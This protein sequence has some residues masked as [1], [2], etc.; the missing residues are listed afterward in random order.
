MERKREMDKKKRIRN[1]NK[2]EEISIIR[3]KKMTNGEL[4]KCIRQGE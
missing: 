3:V 2:K 4:I 1:V